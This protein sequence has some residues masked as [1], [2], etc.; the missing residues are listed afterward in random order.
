MMDRIRNEP[1][2]LGALAEAVV[3][4]VVAVAA[5]AGVDI[6]VPVA[7]AALGVVAVLTGVGV[8]Q[9]AYGPRTVDTIMDADAVIAAA[10][11]GEHE[12]HDP[13]T[14]RG[15]YATGSAGGAT[16]PPDTVG[17]GGPGTRGGRAKR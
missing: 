5:W 2:M 13:V 10:E 12:E 11:R 17:P 4:L 8:R 6:P 9:T 3:A 14:D 15:H 7:A 1:A 16:S